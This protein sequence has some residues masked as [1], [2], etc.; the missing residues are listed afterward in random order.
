MKRSTTDFRRNTDIG[1]LATQP[2][3]QHRGAGTMLLSSI[4]AEA[5]KAGIEVYLEGTDTAKGLYEKHGFRPLKELR[6]DPA[7]YGVC[8]LGTERQTVMVR[9]AMGKD[10][11]RQEVLSYEEAAAQVKAEMLVMHHE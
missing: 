3:H 2:Q 7:E 5:D 1:M 6:F 9:G 11:V 10:G 8:G 4:L